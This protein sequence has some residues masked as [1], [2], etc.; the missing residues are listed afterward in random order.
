MANK[1]RKSYTPLSRL[2]QIAHIIE[3]VDQRC[4][5]ADGCVPKTQDEITTEEMRQIYLLARGY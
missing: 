4:L 5:V 1:F 2:E 3:L